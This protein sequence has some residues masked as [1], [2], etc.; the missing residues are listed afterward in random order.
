MSYSENSE[1]KQTSADKQ[2]VTSEDTEE[3]PELQQQDLLIWALEHNKFERFSSLLEVPGVDPRFKYGKP[4]YTT[5]IELACR[6]QWG[7]KFLK[8]LLMKL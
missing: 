5:C 2:G 3:G 1:F 6:L 4:Y 7:G 8:V